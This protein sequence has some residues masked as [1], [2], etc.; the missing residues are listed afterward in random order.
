MPIENDA[1]RRLF[2]QDD[3]FAVPVLWDRA[4]VVSAFSALFDSEYALIASP[5]LEGGAEGA[6]PQL[7]CCDADL[8]AGRAHGDTVTVNG[9]NYAAVEFK[10]D[11]TGMTTVR[12]R[13]L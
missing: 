9:G 7:H 1:D 10:P 4:G 5:F 6:S 3:D 2:L 12:L 13:E 11:G 8:P